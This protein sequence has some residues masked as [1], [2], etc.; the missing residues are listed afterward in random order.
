MTDVELENLKLFASAGAIKKGHFVYSGGRHG[1]IFVDAKALFSDSKAISKLCRQIAE[2]FKTSAVNSVTG[3]ANNGVVVASW[4]AEHLSELCSKKVALVPTVKTLDDN[5]LIRSASRHKIFNQRVLVVEDILNSGG[6][7]QKV[8]D[9]VRALGGNVVGLGALYNRGGEISRGTINVVD[10]FVSV[11]VPHQS[12]SED[13]CPQCKNRIP[14]DLN[15]GRGKEF[16]VRKG[17][18]LSS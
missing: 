11:N 9:V 4:V 10:F 3:P 2:R 18:V 17:T 13:E 8:I 12:W 14:V 16:L 1:T 15:F 6:S 7:A 5:F